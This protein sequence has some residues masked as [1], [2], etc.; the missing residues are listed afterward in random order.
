MCRPGVD[1]R[2][3]NLLLLTLFWE[4]VI[5]DPYPSVKQPSFN[6]VFFWRL[7]YVKESWMV[8]HAP[9]EQ[10]MLDTRRD[11]E[12]MQELVLMFCWP[13][14]N[15]IERQLCSQMDKMWQNPSFRANSRVKSNHVLSCR[16]HNYYIHMHCRHGFGSIYLQ[17]HNA[18]SFFIIV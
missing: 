2:L 9:S 18:R 7:I 3:T 5:T 14:N 8:C 12:C 13:T 15:Y 10:A 16:Q 4:A 11:C 1:S 17:Q 6:S